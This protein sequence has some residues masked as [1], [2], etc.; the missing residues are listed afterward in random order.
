MPIDENGVFKFYYNNGQLGPFA[1]GYIPVR[2]Y[3][4][5]SNDF[6]FSVNIPEKLIELEPNQVIPI[7][8]NK[9]KKTFTVYDDEADS[10]MDI[11]EIND[12]PLQQQQRS[13]L[14]LR[15]ANSDN[16]NDT[17]YRNIGNFTIDVDIPIYDGYNQS[18]PYTITQNG[19]GV[20]S[21]PQ[22]YEGLGEINYIVNVPQPVYTKPIAVYYRG[23][24]AAYTQ[25]SSFFNIS[26]LTYSKTNYYYR[27]DLSFYL[28]L[29]NHGTIAMIGLNS[30]GS[31]THSDYLLWGNLSTGNIGF[32]CANISFYDA[33]YNS[34]CD[35]YINDSMYCTSASNGMNKLF[36]INF[37]NSEWE[38]V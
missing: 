25:F 1:L 26:D 37:H 21:I 30:S 4:S 27:N 3:D 16:N 31:E 10:D 20:I 38:T 33:N 29:N 13:L 17:S 19:S 28:Y 36:D 14:K 15:D 9:R 18:N 32:K 35:F 23:A 6:D 24:N 5:S 34:I 11:E 22:N 7:S 2:R 8:H 12:Q